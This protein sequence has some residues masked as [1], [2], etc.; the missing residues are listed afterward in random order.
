MKYSTAVNNLYVAMVE[1]SLMRPLDLGNMDSLRAVEHK[2]IFELLLNSLRL[3][4]KKLK[5]RPPG[6]LGVLCILI[7]TCNAYDFNNVSVTVYSNSHILGIWRAITRSASVMYMFNNASKSE[8][9]DLLDGRSAMAFERC[10]LS[11]SRVRQTSVSTS[12]TKLIDRQKVIDSVKGSP[13]Q[14]NLSSSPVL[15]SSC[16]AYQ[17]Y[18]Y[19]IA[20]CCGYKGGAVCIRHSRELT[21]ECTEISMCEDIET[22]ELV[23]KVEHIE[24]DGINVRFDVVRALNLDENSS[25]EDLLYSAKYSYCI[26]PLRFL[27]VMTSINIPK[28]IRFHSK[29][30]LVKWIHDVFGDDTETILWIIG[31]ML[32]DFGN[33]RFFTN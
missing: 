16:I 22:G 12:S 27:R 4:C 13:I 31:D 7:L 17:S 8:L 33:K 10:H 26:C 28:T 18:E 6:D 25:N 32:A 23:V 14:L 19:M 1:K 5:Y 3:E 21:C 15:I 20:D 11:S 2:N 9:H 30:Y 24:N 29:G